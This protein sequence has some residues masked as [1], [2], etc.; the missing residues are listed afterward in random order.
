MKRYPFFAVEFFSRKLYFM[1]Y[2]KHNK[3]EGRGYL[4]YDFPILRSCDDLKLRSSVFS[5]DVIIFYASAE[6]KNKFL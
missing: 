3:D 4:Q 5:C 1:F 2:V 6:K